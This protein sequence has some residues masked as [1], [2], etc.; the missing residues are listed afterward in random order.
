[1]GLVAALAV[2]LFVGLPTVIPQ[3]VALAA[4]GLLAF[5]QAVWNTNRIRQLADPQYQARLQAITSMAFTL[6]LLVGA[7]WAGAAIDRLGNR[8]LLLGAAVLTVCSAASLAR[9]SGART[10]QR[11]G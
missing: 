1:M 8:G 9:S 10:T 6:G 5:A 4:I 2:A 11:V 3:F 7:L